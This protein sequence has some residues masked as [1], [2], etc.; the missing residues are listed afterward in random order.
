MPPEGNGVSPPARAL[1]PPGLPPDIPQ[2]LTIG[3]IAEK[4]DLTA[5]PFSISE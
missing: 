3:S 2:G 4:L 1:R 5:R